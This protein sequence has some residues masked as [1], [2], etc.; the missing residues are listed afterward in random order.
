MKPEKKSSDQAAT[1]FLFNVPGSTINWAESNH[2]KPS[3]PDRIIAKV[4][5]K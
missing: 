2:N 5:E 3:K 1:G 4:V